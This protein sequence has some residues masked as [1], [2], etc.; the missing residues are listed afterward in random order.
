M[1]VNLNNGA[2]IFKL[3]AQKL[4]GAVIEKLVTKLPALKNH[5]IDDIHNKLGSDNKLAGL[6]GDKGARFQ[7]AIHWPWLPPL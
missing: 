3:V 6:L 5:S 2:A 7:R 4:E 1:Q